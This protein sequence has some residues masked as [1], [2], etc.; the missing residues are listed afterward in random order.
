MGR[1]ILVHI[2][3]RLIFFSLSLSFSLVYQQNSYESQQDV[4]IVVVDELV[5]FL[6]FRPPSPYALFS[7]SNFSLTIFID[8]CRLKKK[9]TTKKIRSEREIF[10]HQDKQ[11][12][13]HYQH[14]NA[15]TRYRFVL[16]C[17]WATLFSDYLKLPNLRPHFIR[18]S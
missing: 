6:F 7:P 11:L 14:T 17:L 4:C 13:N 18:C 1:G 10:P 16:S 5:S 8:N 9:R 2:L 12:E 15:P 3:R